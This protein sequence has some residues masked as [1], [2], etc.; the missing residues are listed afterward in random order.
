MKTTLNIVALSLA[1]T[2]VSAVARAD[3]FAGAM[4]QPDRFA[5]VAVDAKVDAA[6]QLAAG[7][8]AYRRGEYAEAFRYY[9]N[10]S[11]LGLAEA[12]YRL[13]MMYMSGQGTRKSL[14]QAEYWMSSAARAHYPGAAEALSLIR[15][16]SE[17]G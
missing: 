5:M 1:C 16:M 6:A 10:V 3:S 15:A 11:T 2:L 7:N 8:A 4:G 13:R 9:R 14:S 12:Q 17:Q